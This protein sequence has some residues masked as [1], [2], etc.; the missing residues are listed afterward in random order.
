MRQT[1]LKR[2]I[3]FARALDRDTLR[4][5]KLWRWRNAMSAGSFVMELAAARA[6]R[7][8]TGTLEGRFK[9]V[10]RRLAEQ[11]EFARLVEPA[12]SSNVVSEEIEPWRKRDIAAAAE[13]ALSG[14]W[15][16]VVW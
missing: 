3:E 15:Q 5:L 11:L 14:P 8:F 4:L 7:G 10:L 13:R 12:N 16:H 9:R 1:S 2:H 6:L